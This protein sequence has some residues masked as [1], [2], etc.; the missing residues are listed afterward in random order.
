MRQGAAVTVVFALRDVAPI[1]P[2]IETSIA[3]GGAC[4]H[5]PLQGSEALETLPQTTLDSRLR[6]NDGFFCLPIIL[7]Y[8]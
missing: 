2:L 8:F 7:M 4:P 1:N 5:P 3:S 6:G